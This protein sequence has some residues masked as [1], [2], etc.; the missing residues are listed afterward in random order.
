MKF[1]ELPKKWKT[2][3]ITLSITTLLSF[4]ALIVFITSTAGSLI[5]VMIG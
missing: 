1:R 5:H 2:I 3:I 4:I